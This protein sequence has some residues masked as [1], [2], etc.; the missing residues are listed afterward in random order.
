MSVRTRRPS[1]RRTWQ[2][3]AGIDEAFVA[4]P[5]RSCCVD[6]RTTRLGARARE[7][8]R[9]DALAGDAPARARRPRPSSSGSGSSTTWSR[10][11]AARACAAS[12]RATSGAAGDRRAPRRGA[13]GA[14]RAAAGRVLEVGVRV[15][16][17]GLPRRPRRGRSGELVGVDL[18]AATC[19]ASRR[20]SRTSGR[21]RSPTR[22]STGPARLDARARSAPTTRSTASR[23]APDDIG[24]CGR[25]RRA[26]PG[27]APVGQPARHRP[28]RRAARLRLV[29]AGRHRRLDGALHDASSG[30]HQELEALRARRLIGLDTCGADHGG[31]PRGPRRSEVRAVPAA[32]P[33]RRG[34]PSSVASAGR[35][36]YDYSLSGVARAPTARAPRRRAGRQNGREVASAE[37][38]RSILAADGLLAHALSS[39]KSRRWHGRWPRRRSRRNAA[40][41]DRDHTFPRELFSK[42]GELG[43]MGVCVPEELGGAGADFLSYILVLEE[44]SRADAGVGVTVAVHTSAVTPADRRV[45]DATSRSSGSCPS[46]RA[47]RVLG[48]FALTEPERR[49]RRRGAA[50]DGGPGRRRLADRAAP[51]QWITNGSHAATFLALRPHRPVRRAARGVSAPSSSTEPT[52]R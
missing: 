13:V 19:R 16:R 17:A 9:R 50:V 34:G 18:A 3:V 49:I 29:P 41:W 32:A 12:A 30:S 15:R 46:S 38:P 39:A 2:T 52:S 27:P 43:L 36:F 5:S 22:R 8:R 51:K 6:L 26:S 14:R 21:C 28:A 42:L 35:G 23:R 37:A 25:A 11:R 10:S 33:L 4:R 44:L 45:R 1:R 20:S 24:R 40:A 48:A 31:P 47:G 7:A